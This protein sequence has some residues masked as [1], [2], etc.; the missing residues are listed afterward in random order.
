[1]HPHEGLVHDM[2][3]GFGQQAVNVG[4]APVGRVLHRK[5]RLIGL[6]ARHGLDH[7]LEGGAGQRLEL[8]ARGVAGLM[9]VGTGFSLKGDALG[10][11]ST[12]SEWAFRR[13]PYTLP[14]PVETP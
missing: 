1:M 11:V 5:H 3:A 9:R 7:R 12:L 10:H 13:A 14:P 4:H 8:R 2:Q 6:A